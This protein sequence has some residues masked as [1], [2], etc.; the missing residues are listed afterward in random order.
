MTH[1]WI[2]QTALRVGL[3][4]VLLCG[5]LRAASALPAFAFRKHTL[6]LATAD[7]KPVPGASVYG[8]CRE[9]GLLWPR[10]DADVGRDRDD[11]I[12]WE[13]GT[14]DKN[15]TISV[16]VPP[17]RWGFFAV[18]TRGD[19]ADARVVVA[20]SEDR[21]RE[22]NEAI[23][24]RASVTRH[25][26]L[27]A[28]DGRSLAPKSL[29]FRPDGL[30]IWIP[31]TLKQPAESLAIEAS[32]GRLQ[33]FAQADA[34]A[35]RPGFAL[36]FGWVSEKTPDGKLLGPET[37][38]VVDCRSSGPA[39]L[40]WRQ[41]PN[42]GLGGEIAMNGNAKVLFS[43]GLVALSY[44]RPVTPTLM[45][46]FVAQTHRLESSP[47]LRLDLDG[48]LDAAV[49]QAMSLDTDKPQV[50]ARLYLVDRNGQPLE[51]LCDASGKSATIN[52]TVSSGGQRYI[53]QPRP[54][55]SD[56]A[57]VGDGG[58]TMFDAPIPQ[59]DPA[60]VWEFSAPPG[61]LPRPRNTLSPAA[62]VPVK[63]R[64]FEVDVPQILSRH[65]A[66]VLEQAEVTARNMETITGR[67]RRA[68]V[69]DLIVFP[70][71]G[72]AS[73]GHNG[74]HIRYGTCL[75]FSDAPT[76]R[77]TFVHELGHSFD[78]Y[79][80]GLHETVVE[81]T[82]TIACDPISQQRAK[83]AFMDRMNGLKGRGT[84]YPDQ[85]LYL[86]CYGQA[87]QRFLRFLIVNEPAVRREL[88]KTNDEFTDEELTAALLTV[89]MG[90]DM[91]EI[92]NAYRLKVTSDRVAQAV[93][94]VRRVCN[95]S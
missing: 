41:N 85:G 80:G 87:G 30:P 82:R 20:W 66:N 35:D 10:P 81:A 12:T 92:C 21:A 1:R 88:G 8:F 23:E 75:F 7:G 52:A 64:T 90:R 45:G 3:V 37:T 77:H 91:L 55:K 2:I 57:G 94:A 16:L 84:L 49:D 46:S 33:L 47:A 79:H 63:S 72:G 65:A 48:P 29:Y 83:W 61:V 31:A 44:R 68:P 43:P 51:D 67:T 42:V 71:S 58:I 25:W 76:F 4:T 39:W 74:G 18:G 24:L 36:A 56:I 9:Y 62:H 14:T 15:G 40:I 93:T 19:G 70:R 11:G 22:A 26:T 5:P 6:S 38:A 54:G 28:H 17:G 69:T 13:L 32:A 50:F 86:Y 27:C 34:T 73:S 89:A 53:A 95:R 59:L 78:F 60:A